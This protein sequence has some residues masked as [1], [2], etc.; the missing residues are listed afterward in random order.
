[1]TRPGP[2]TMNRDDVEL[3]EHDT[4]FQGY[5]RMDRYQLRHRKYDGQWSRPITR[6]VLERGHAA[7]VLPYDP[8]TDR[9]VLIEQFRTG[10]F[11]HGAVDKNAEPWQIEIVA[12]IID[13]GESGESVARREAVE[14]AGCHIMGKLLPVMNYYMSPG[15]VSEYMEVYCGRCDTSQIGGTH[16]LDEEDE[17]IRVLVI[18]FQQAI[19]LMNAGK[20]RNSPAIIALQWLQLHHAKTRK[21]FF[22]QI[23]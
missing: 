1:M 4:V 10:A 22:K 13:D 23:P 3:L 15:A 16:G 7:A 18:S 5:Y 8:D 17:D 14:E 20:I 11:A 19:A 6:E 21:Q 2:T 9:V 12:G